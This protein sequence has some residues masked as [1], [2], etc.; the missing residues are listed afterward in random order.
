M[1]PSVPLVGGLKR[2]DALAALGEES[3]ELGELFLI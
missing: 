2:R 3:V 1:G